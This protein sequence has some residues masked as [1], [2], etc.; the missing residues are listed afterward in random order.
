MKQLPAQTLVGALK[1]WIFQ[2][3]KGRPLRYMP[4]HEALIILGTWCEQVLKRACVCSGESYNWVGFRFFRS[5]ICYICCFLVFQAICDQRHVAHAASEQRGRAQKCTCCCSRLLAQILQFVL[6]R[7]SW[8][9][10]THHTSSSIAQAQFDATKWEFLLALCFQLELLKLSTNVLFHTVS[11][12]L[13]EV[14]KDIF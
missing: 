14:N 4:I 9:Q 5:Y 6:M 1:P 10:I 7:G 13:K 8:Q 3:L 2:L 11:M 12:K